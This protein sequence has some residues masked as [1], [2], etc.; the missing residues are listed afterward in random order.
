MNGATPNP[1]SV[2]LASVHV[3]GVKDLNPSI[4]PPESPNRPPAGTAS[5]DSA[6]TDNP[7]DA[8]SNRHSSVAEKGPSRDDTPA[9]S[10]FQKRER[11]RRRAYLLTNCAFQLVWG[12]LYT[13]YSIK[14]TYLT[15][16][17]IFELGSLLCVLAP[18]S[19]AFIVGRAIAGVGS[20]GVTNGG[21]LLETSN[22]QLIQ[23]SI[24]FQAIKG[25][26]AMK[27]G[28]MSLP[29][30]L[31]LLTFSFLVGTLTSGLGYYLQLAY[32]SITFMAVG[33]GLLATFQVD[34]RH[35][36]L[37]GYEFILSAGVGLGLQ[38]AS[39][40]TQKALPIADIPI[41][42]ATIFIFRKN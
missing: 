4:T 37:I 29:M 36:E 6:G 7:N 13:F 12:K 11:K 31:S 23:T 28:V 20:G 26:S 21:F 40:A 8:E 33:T 18:N 9:S 22:R 24:G 39:V 1:S 34:S 2:T 32:L 41:G 16:L 42:T 35:S 3:S 5:L 17:F 14:W 19:T 10:K 25:T 30:I 15:A 27:S 38:A